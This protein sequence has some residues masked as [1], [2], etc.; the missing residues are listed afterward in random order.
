MEA[1]F[2]ANSRTSFFKLLEKHNLIGKSKPKDPINQPTS[3]DHFPAMNLDLET[4]EKSAPDSLLSIVKCYVC[5]SFRQRNNKDRLS[6]S[7]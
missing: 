7:A 3:T 6:H 5:L 2:C 1:G 4:V